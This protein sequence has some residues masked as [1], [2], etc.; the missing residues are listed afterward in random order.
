MDGK[1]F[2]ASKG[3]TIVELLVVIVVIGILAGISVTA[4]NGIQQR[5]RNATRI[6]SVNQLIKVVQIAALDVSMTEM[7]NSLNTDADGWYRA[8]LGTGYED[9]SADG[10]GDCGVYSGT[11]Y[12]SESASFHALLSSW[13]SVPSMGSYPVLSLHGDVVSGPFIESAWVDGADKLV[14][15][16]ALEGEEQDCQ[17]DPLVYYVD[18]DTRT[19]TPSS[20]PN[21]SQSEQ[22]MT[23]CI[24]PVYE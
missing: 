17:L 3:F 19:M 2:R 18:A 9:V 14:I 12:V 24:V 16:Y 4:Y 15:E 1:Y 5:A 7:T 22:G 20:T 21:Y 11:P 8:C 6:H 13:S 10:V 23:S